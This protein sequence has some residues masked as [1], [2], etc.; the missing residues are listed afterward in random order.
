MSSP[1]PVVFRNRNQ[2]TLYGL[3]HTPPG[4]SPGDLVVLLLS[5]GVKMRVGPERLYLRMT[6][7]L[8]ELGISVLRFDFHGLGDSEGTLPEERLK[9]VYS[10]I[11]LGRYVDDTVDAM[12]WM[13]QTY[14]CRRFLLSG[15]CGGAITS[16][17]AGARDKRVVGLFGIGMTAVLAARSADAARYMTIGQL[18]ASQKMYLR[19]LLSPKAW[20]RL[21]T[22][23]TNNQLIKRM[24]VHWSRRLL[25]RAP[26]TVASAPPEDD[27]AN[28]LFPPAFFTMMSTRR[29]MLFVFG[30]GDRL[31]WEYEEKFV[32]RHRER[33]A[34]MPP[35][36]DVH[37]VEQANHVL[38]LREWQ[39]EMLDVATR[40]MK[41]H[42]MADIVHERDAAPIRATA[43]SHV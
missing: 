30:G 33:L 29:P 21:L 12:N 5:P 41:R 3:L 16:L 31:H 23:Q 42:F 43:P 24:V 39:D 18:E 36:V 15:L 35:L 19:R 10:H 27:N 32:A 20:Y 11:E 7:R 34:S 13:E 38:S 25:G 28:P 37:V 26:Q 17:L 40:W 2:L 1:I 14:G 9:D 8:L 6:E 22:F 4:K